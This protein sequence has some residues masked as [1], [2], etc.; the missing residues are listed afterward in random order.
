M[1]GE[2]SKAKSF[3]ITFGIV[4]GPGDFL[5]LLLRRT[6]YAL[7]CVTKNSAGTGLRPDR[8]EAGNRAKFTA[9]AM[10]CTDSSLLAL[11]SVYVYGPYGSK[12][13]IL[14]FV[15]VRQYWTSVIILENGNVIWKYTWKLV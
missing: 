4:S 14:R 5:T 2:T 9:N 3:Q 12:I 10:Q 13:I 6:L 11:Q 8:V 1:T 15:A 7:C